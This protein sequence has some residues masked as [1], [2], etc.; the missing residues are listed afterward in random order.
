MAHL[1]IAFLT[2]DVERHELSKQQPVSIGSH[3]SNDICIDEDGVD[4]MH[5]RVAWN[6]T[7]FEAVAAGVEGI[8]VN[9]S[10]V[11]RAM[12]SSGNVLRFGSVDLTFQSGDAEPGQAAAAGDED[13][14]GLKPLTDEIPVAAK[15]A[16]STPAVDEKSSTGKKDADSSSRKENRKKSPGEDVEAESV[17]EVDDVLEEVDDLFEEDAEWDEAS[18]LDGLAAESRVDTP[19]RR[20]LP[21]REGE[22]PQ[23]DDVE[24][25]GGNESAGTASDSQEASQ[26]KE[27]LN[28]RLR[29]S[30]RARQQRP[31]DEDTLRSPLVLGLGGTVAVLVL[32]GVTFYFIAGRNTTQVEFEAAE[33]LLDEGKYAPA[34]AQFENFIVNHPR[35]S[36]SDQARLLM[37]RARI[38][39]H[40]KGAAPRWPDGLEA[41]RS[42]V[43]EHRDDDDFESQ[44]T[45]VWERA[46]DISLGAAE[47]AGRSYDPDL[48]DVSDQAETI[49]ST[50][51][52]QD[53]PPEQ[54]LKEIDDT[55]RASAAAILRDSTFNSALAVLDQQLED[56]QTMQALVT[57]RD[58]LVQYPDVA[59]DRIRGPKLA[60][61]LQT[62][63]DTERVL[64]ESEDLNRA[65][66]TEE[67]ESED[68]ATV[69]LIYLARSRTGE[70]SVEQ[71]VPVLSQDCCYGVDTVTG[72]NR[73]R[74]VIGLNTP[75][76]PLKEPT[77]PSLILFD[78]NHQELVRLDQNSGALVWRQP[79]EGR[80]T[81]EP[82]LFEGQIYLPTED[83]SLYK[84]DL[85]SGSISTRL[86][87]S[88]SITGPAITAEGERLVVVGDREVAYTLGRRPLSCEAVSFLGQKPAS[89]QAPL[90][91]M[92][93][94]ILM[95]EN[96]D[97]DHSRLR[98]IDT[99]DP[100][101][102][103][104]LDSAEIEG[105]VLDAPV[106]RG[107]DLFVPSTGE[108]VSTFTVS[109]DPGDSPLVAGPTYQVTG[110]EQGPVFLTLLAGP[111]RQLWM[112]SSALRKLQLST[113]SLEADQNVVSAGLASQPL[114]YTGGSLF[115]A[116]R[117]AY[118][119][120]VTLTQT[121]RNEL[122]SEWRVVLGARLLACSTH[123]GESTI[124]CVTEAGNLFRLSRD[125]WGEGGVIDQAESLPLSADEVE[126]PLLAT[127]LPEGQIA[128][129]VGEPSPRAWVV[130][131]R[132]QID[133]TYELDDPLQ[134]PPVLF[135]DQ[136][137]LAL[138][139]RIQIARSSQQSRIQE[140]AVASDEVES[141]VWRQI[142]A[143][144]ENNLIAVTDDGQ[145]IQVRFQSN[146]RAHLGEVSRVR[147]PSPVD[148][149]G[150]L[151]DGLLA[152]ADSGDSVRIYDAASLDPKGEI[153]LSASV[154]NDVWLIAGRLYVETDQRELRCLDIEDGLNE[155]WEQPLALE[156]SGL[157]GPP[158]LQGSK[159]VVAE[160]DGRVSV[161]DAETGN[162]ENTISTGSPVTGSILT[163]SGELLAP[164]LDGSLMNVSA[165]LTE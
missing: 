44:V 129:A 60:Q 49:L 140:F 160:R 41:L 149:R 47:A 51:I 116:R 107:K 94:Y 89:V 163:V 146:P 145:L 124:M 133:R 43:G 139:G 76:F 36:F 95:A 143:V 144:D 93:P 119:E 38:D 126:S 66:I 22:T 82:L 152:I 29:Q 4:L 125:D 33:Q 19:S 128:I 7:G 127:P 118:S 27:P 12:L 46:G 64:V 62:T 100:Q 48:L 109:D 72:K 96:T 37:D 11:Q 61:R 59:Q 157:A 88:Q 14:V 79:I 16:I 8:D 162:H 28:E 147:L 83:G 120:S 69:S 123:E 63:L 155:L 138:P 56:K 55:Q 150:D 13:E 42:F 101:N 132:G 159:L 75:F 92:G 5:C 97:A 6:K 99:R 148:F 137:V 135:G 81:G 23:A 80:A 20:S 165:V 1:E 35:G 87:F 154:S 142:L 114:Q 110:S 108:R 73:W 74:R 111:D 15:K 25:L 31:G 122:L 85:E 10:L 52:P 21:G 39:Q 30:M 158:L 84:I 102:L 112:A 161:A 58:L 106:I 77:L 113:D 105:H 3:K 9:G 68:A 2:G 104:E 32:V 40:I 151:A 70:D 34:I 156:G 54:L 153:Q 26:P 90:L 131:R 17:P 115:N 117:L 45:G 141:T 24:E 164:L 98:L 130:T 86:K 65:G 67:R 91:A 78:T 121:D 53:N 18:G 103:V 50:Y 136:L 57:W 71:A 134:L